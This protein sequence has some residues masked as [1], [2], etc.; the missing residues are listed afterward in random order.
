MAQCHLDQK[1]LSKIAEVIGKP[2]KYTREQI[3]KRASRQNISAE[4][5][6]ILWAKQLKIGT[7]RFQRSLPSNVQD[8]IRNALQRSTTVR[9]IPVPVLSSN[10][11]TSKQAKRLKNSLQPMIEYIVVDTD[12]RERC[13]D[14]LK[15]KSKFDRVI[16]EATTVLDDRLKAL[17]NITGKMNPND[18][19]G[20]VLNPDPAKAILIASND[21]DEQ[22]G[23]FSLCK[24][25]FLAFRNPA[26]HRLSDK[27]TREDALRFC[28]FVDLILAILSRA[29]V[30][31]TN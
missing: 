4:A 11:K 5:V 26:H 22:Q 13:G 19:V 14:L 7:S 30:N 25:L 24:G 9:P 21:G 15:A 10:G 1:I 20:K 29:K 8:D 2:V 6:Q 27:F 16:R 31:S 23:I 3:S 12:L 17:G 28:G 18:L